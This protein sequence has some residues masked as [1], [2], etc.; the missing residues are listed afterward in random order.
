[1]N[2]LLGGEE[3][4]AR[5][6]AS[7]LRGRAVASGLPNRDCPRDSAGR[8]VLSVSPRAHVRHSLK[9]GRMG[10]LGGLR[11]SEPSPNLT[12]TGA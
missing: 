5:Y 10:E 11:A 1:M 7:L 6:S 2:V 9:E 4:E 12:G 8:R 3:A